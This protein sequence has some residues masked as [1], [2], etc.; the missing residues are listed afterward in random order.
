MVLTIQAKQTSSSTNELPKTLVGA[1]AINKFSEV[2]TE[3][4][5]WKS[6][7]AR[8]GH[9]GIMKSLSHWR[10]NLKELTNKFHQT[11]ATPLHM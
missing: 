4:R 10:N 6:N 5:H 11:N 2:E 7:M 9:G 1:G 3:T 8:T